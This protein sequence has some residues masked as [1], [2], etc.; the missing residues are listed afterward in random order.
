MEINTSSQ[1][2]SLTGAT[3]GAREGSQLDRDA[4]MQLLVT[5][6]QNQDPLDPMDPREMVTQLSELTSVEHLMGIEQQLTALDTGMA[7]LA[8]VQASNFVGSQVVADGSSLHLDTQGSATGSFTLPAAADRVEVA[9]RDS[10]GQTVQTLNLGRTA[11]GGHDFVWDGQSAGGER[12]TAGHYSVDVRATGAN[13]QPLS[14]STQV[15]GVVQAV[16]YDRGM[17][18]LSV[19]DRHFRLSDVVSVGLRSTQASEGATL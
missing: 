11:A 5:Q 2:A 13:G 7:S 12:L 15:T 16:R 9:I 4:F 1:A 14:V 17:T 18:E 8:N 10:S 6:L 3:A 19:G